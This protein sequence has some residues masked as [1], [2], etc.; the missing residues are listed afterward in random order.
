MKNGRGVWKGLKL[1]KFLKFGE[2]RAL[3]LLSAIRGKNFEKMKFDSYQQLGT[4][5]H[6]M[7]QKSLSRSIC[8]SF[9]ARSNCKSNILQN[10]S[11]VQEKG[12]R[13]VEIWKMLDKGEKEGSKN[14]C[15][16]LGIPFWMS[17]YRD[18]FVP[19]LFSVRFDKL[20][21]ISNGK[22]FVRE[23]I[24]AEKRSQNDKW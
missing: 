11:D 21:L 22:K 8:L 4:K 19:V 18:I 7:Q 9:S 17:A 2:G 6:F 24:C 15:F 10:T 12:R 23:D 5:E 16:F 20:K 14:P 3:L 13:F 1:H